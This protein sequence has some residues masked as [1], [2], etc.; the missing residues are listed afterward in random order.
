MSGL[1]YPAAYVRPR[2]PR[3]QRAAATRAALYVAALCLLGLAVTWVVAELVPA[4]QVKDALLLE[5]FA[6]HDTPSVERL[7]NFALGLLSPALFVIWAL[8]LVLTALA[9]GRG[10]LALGLAA[11]L[12]L[13]PL[14]ANL[15]KPLL[16][17]PHARVGVNHIDSASWPS[18]HATAAFALAACAALAVPARH[19]A[20]VAAF[21]AAFT[22]AIGCAL[23]IKAWH[24]PSDVLGGYLLAALWTALAVAAVSAAERRRQGAARPADGA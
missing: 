5:R 7:A 19:R 15:L 22:L 1:L 8:A 18:G 6:S 16:A 4:A 3:D 21:G 24:L 2:L 13:A 11:V 20:V 9:R 23:L 12:G 10:L 14:S 17:H